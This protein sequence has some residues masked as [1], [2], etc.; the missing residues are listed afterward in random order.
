MV[1]ISKALE[2]YSEA[3]TSSWRNLDTTSLENIVKQ[4]LT[5]AWDHFSYNVEVSNIYFK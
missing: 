2:T 4:L 3:L 5:F 1:G